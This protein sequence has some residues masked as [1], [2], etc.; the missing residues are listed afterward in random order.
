MPWHPVL[1]ACGHLRDCRPGSE[2]ILPQTFR[3]FD[4][5]GVGKGRPILVRIRQISI[6]ETRARRA[7]ARGA[8]FA[9]GSVWATGGELMISDGVVASL[10]IR[11]SS[12]RYV[13]GMDPQTQATEVLSLGTAACCGAFSVH[14]RQGS[15]LR[16]LRSA[17]TVLVIT[18]VQGRGS[19]PN[20]TP[21]P[22]PRAVE[23]AEH[24]GPGRGTSR[25]GVPR[26]ARQPQPP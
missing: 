19:R 5:K 24:L 23:A 1:G 16:C 12:F 6:S 4:V 18:C 11:H 7:L 10:G 21:I 3:R 25:N 26:G 20:E 9:K 8:I 22:I 14:C 17:H 13:L 15:L 2:A